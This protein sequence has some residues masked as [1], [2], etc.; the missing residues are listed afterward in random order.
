ML[1]TLIMQFFFR[2]ILQV[3]RKKKKD[4]EN[5]KEGK[6]MQRQSEAAAIK[7]EVEKSS[8]NQKKTM[9]LLISH[10]AANRIDG[11]LLA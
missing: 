8:G 7:N 11:R 6:G 4:M 5:R 1:C 2:N 3:A 10:I 9:R